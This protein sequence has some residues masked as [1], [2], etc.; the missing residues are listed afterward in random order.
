M[1]YAPPNLLEVRTLLLAHLNVDKANY[2]YDD[3]ESIEV[4]IVGDSAH[5]G[6]YH[7]GSDRVVSRDYSVIESVR[8]SRGLTL[9]A[10]ALDVG[11][12]EAHVNG[13]THNLY[14]F[15][16]WVIS[17][18][19]ANAPDT[20]DIREVIYTPDGK[21]VRRYDR[22]GKRSSGDSSHLYH[23]HFSF[24]RDSVK[25]R[26]DQTPLFKR[27]LT[28]IGLLEE[29]M[30]LNADDLRAVRNQVALGIYDVLWV[31]ANGKDFNNLKYSGS[32]SIGETVALNL[33]KLT[34]VPLL[35]LIA[36]KVDIDENELAAIKQAATEGVAAGADALIA[37]IVSRLPENLAG[38]SRDQV[39]SAVE[40]GVRG[41]FS[42]GL[43]EGVQA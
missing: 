35:E 27:Y 36:A 34:G 21:T 6:G 20:R 38:M 8:D 15:N 19:I 1:T 3:L 2:R 22:L 13:I 4:G 31:A 39:V 17:Q 10:S 42:H 14:T 28:Y 7:C 24:F 41:A 9:D 40:E 11:W 23:T 37:E 5:R 25:A 32:G 30:P 29:D 18:C 43:A 16:R 12:F 33:G 26:R